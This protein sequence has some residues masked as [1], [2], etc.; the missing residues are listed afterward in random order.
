MSRNKNKAMGN[1][2]QVQGPSLLDSVYQVLNKHQGKDF[3]YKQI[4]GML[5][6]GSKEKRLQIAEILKE[7]AKKEVIR[8]S[9]PGKYRMKREEKYLVGT[10]EC[11]ASGAGFVIVPEMEQDVFIP[12]RGMNRALHGDTVKIKLT[13]FK[14]KPEGEIVEVIKRSRDQFIGTIQISAKFAFFVPDNQKIKVDFYIPSSKINGANSGEKVIA[15]I[16]DWPKDS[17]NPFGKIVEVLGDARNNDV[18]MHSILFEYELPEKFPAD[19]EQEADKIPMELDPL[20]IKKRRDF[21]SITTF[22]IDPQDAKDFDDALSVHKLEN[23]NYEIGVHIADV[24]H[25]VKEGS[26]LDVEAFNRATSIYLVDRV[27]PMLPEKLSNGV[28]SLRPN[29]E[30]FCFSAVFEINDKAEVLNEWFGRTVIYSDRRFAYEEAQKVIETGEGDFKEEILLLDKLAKQMRHERLRKGGLA[31][32]RIEVKFNLDEKGKPLGVYFK[33]SKDANKLIEEFMLLANKQVASFVGKKGKT[34]KTFVYRIHDKPSPDKFGQF[35]NFAT[36]FGYFIKPKNE[37]EIAKSLSKFLEDVKGKKESNML[38]TLAIRTMAK[39]EYSTHNI[40]HYGLGFSH[41]SHFTSP[42]R[43]Y[44]DVLAHRLLQRYLDGEPSVSAEEYE[45]MCIHSSKQEKKASEA[46]RDSIKYKQ[47]E[48]MMDKVGQEFEAL[49]SGVTEWGI[50]A[51]IIENLCEGMISIRS[52]TDDYY[53]FDQDN[54]CL[55]GKKLGDKFQLGDRLMIQIK[56]A[57]LAKRQLDYTFVK[58]IEEDVIPG[59]K[60]KKK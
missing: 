12:F 52:L 7:L 53:V 34:P 55:V 28:C 56:N 38:E 54:Y 39:A 21:R 40:G 22:T 57:D 10:L 43:R 50:Y 24:S 37:N 19:V 42:I 8:E 49:I 26:I 25:Y 48:F 60:T 17:K 11:I 20:E 33:E 31:F 23:G 35:S 1:G 2:G 32:D 5:N 4:A 44:P 36:Q 16:T 27:V 15:E 18:V 29:E 6:I 59:I 30:K 51:E 46:E 13:G 14:N 3:N 9:S 45:E 58:K 47:V 41:Y